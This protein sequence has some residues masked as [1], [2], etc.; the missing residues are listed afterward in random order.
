MFSGMEV[1]RWRDCGVQLREV[2]SHSV[3]SVSVEKN[4]VSMMLSEDG[5]RQAEV[6][7]SVI[8]GRRIGGA[9]NFLLNGETLRPKC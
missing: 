7:N 4:E 2:T 6:E 3:L 8:Q 1:V 9:L 5:R